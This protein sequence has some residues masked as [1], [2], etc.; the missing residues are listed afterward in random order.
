[1]LNSAGEG[2]CIEAFR[3]HKGNRCLSLPVIWAWKFNLGDGKG[4][5]FELSDS[6][7]LDL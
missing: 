3:Q 2:K 7:D 6:K 5:A 4:S 1:M